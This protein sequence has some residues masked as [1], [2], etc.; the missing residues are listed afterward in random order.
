VSERDA[1]RPEPV[2]VP[3]A[4]HQVS[5]VRISE[6][7]LKVM[8]RLYRSGFLAYLVGGAVRD[9]LL[10]RRPKDFDIGTN[11]RPQ[12]VRQ[13]FRNARLIG[14]RFR[15]AR[16]LFGEEVV[17][18]ATFRRSPAAPEAD[19]GAAADVLAPAP[20]VDEYGSPE[21]DAWRRDFTVNGLFYNIA[22][23][24]I[25]DYVGGLADLR[26]G[27]IRS[28][29]TAPDRFTEDPVRM[30]RAVEYAARLGFRMDAPT[31][32]AIATLHGEI[33]RA[34]PARIAYEL[35]E[36]LTGGYAEAI[37]RGL[38]EQG[39]LAHILP[40]ILEGDGAGTS[41]TRWRL[42]G[43]ADAL[44]RKGERLAEETLLATLFVP[45][46]WP[47]VRRTASGEQ[48]QSDL[49]SALTAV[50]EPPGRRLGISNFRAHILRGAFAQLPRFAT[51][52]RS[53]K[54][55][56]RSVRRDS[57]PVALQLA[58]LLAA[59]GLEPAEPVSEWERI[60]R[61]VAAGEH[62]FEGQ[63]PRPQRRRRPHR[64]RRRRSAP[65]SEAHEAAG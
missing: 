59:A 60:A 20:D 54:Q 23:F 30:M 32:E 31:S 5:R 24:S 29:G 16:V 46:L 19:D 49:E 2:V 34:A 63:A 18:V 21:E 15:L 25:I 22:D 42:L 28:I 8:Y 35:M 41:A 36:S 47:T 64:G 12:Q 3:R 44:V 55:A 7:A 11:A 51:A 53:S 39:L 50:L 45:A 61:R 48:R 6:N 43:L 37:F 38:E 14:R 10:G 17:E 52:P 62:P 27:L 33:R 56:V 26:E 13:L 58:R 40:E 57:F 1:A 4:D 65:S 9:L